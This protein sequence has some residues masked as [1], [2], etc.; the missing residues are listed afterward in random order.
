MF[1]D[2]MD[3]TV[4]RDKISEVKETIF[5][6]PG[7]VPKMTNSN[8]KEYFFDLQTS[9][10]YPRINSISTRHFNLEVAFQL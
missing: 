1:L 3:Y 8:T 9:L 10:L 7:V 4:F 6:L 5:I 2:V